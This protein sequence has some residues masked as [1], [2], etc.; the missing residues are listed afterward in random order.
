[1]GGVKFMG[2]YKGKKRQPVYFNNYETTRAPDEREACVPYESEERKRQEKLRLKR[3][4]EE[5]EEQEENTEEKDTHPD[6]PEEKIDVESPNDNFDPA[7]DVNLH[8]YRRKLSK[9]KVAQSILNEAGIDAV[10]ENN[11][12]LPGVESMTEELHSPSVTQ[13]KFIKDVVR[14]YKEDLKELYHE[15][16]NDDG[17][18]DEDDITPGMRRAARY[19]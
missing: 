6:E 7:H 14:D 8:S 11:G 16:N 5:A 15:D 2:R 3:A 18:V 4:F 12:S 10:V 1:M 9:V 19:M 17:E 13:D